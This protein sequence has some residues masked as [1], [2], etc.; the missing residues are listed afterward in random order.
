M[1]VRE[2]RNRR[3]DIRVAGKGVLKSF[4]NI[5]R[6]VSDYTVCERKKER[7]TEIEIV[8][9]CVCVYVCV[10]MCV[11]I[12]VMKTTTMLVQKQLPAER[13]K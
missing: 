1:L 7:E 4:W 6:R 8:C 9:V 12:H 3:T 2:Q 5:S 10:C 11:Y 13:N